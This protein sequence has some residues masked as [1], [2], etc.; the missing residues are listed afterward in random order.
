LAREENKTQVVALL[1][2]D[3]CQRLE[4]PAPLYKV[5][6]MVLVDVV[7]TQFVRAILASLPICSKWLACPSKG[8]NVHL[9]LVSFHFVSRY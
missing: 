3:F 2:R 5:K 7:C 6:I 1:K 9:H 8:K 4:L